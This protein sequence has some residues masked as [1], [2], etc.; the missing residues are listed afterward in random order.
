MQPSE[1]KKGE[2]LVVGFTASLFF[3]HK[4]GN[5]S[6]FVNTT[7][8]DYARLVTYNPRSGEVLA[9]MFSN[10]AI[11]Q[12]SKYARVD[13]KSFK[14]SV[15][16]QEVILDFGPLIDASFPSISKK[17]RK[18]ANVICSDYSIANEWISLPIHSSILVGPRA[19]GMT[20]NACRER[21]T[22]S[23]AMGFNL[24]E[25]KEVSI[26]EMCCQHRACEKFGMLDRTEITF[27]EGNNSAYQ[28]PLGFINSLLAAML[29]KGLITETALLS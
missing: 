7:D 6:A 19:E 2:G 8:S 13:R 14:K 11:A 26:L 28:G 29:K 16:P 17:I 10:L 5:V 9:Y 3:L 23:T 22:Y 25:G 24:M 1:T 21:Y 20:G 12:W 18:Y 15:T 4:S 27:K